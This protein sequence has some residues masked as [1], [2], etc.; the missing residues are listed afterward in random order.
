M[1]ALHFLQKI[2]Q[3]K[4]RMKLSK[5]VNVFVLVKNTHT[6]THKRWVKT[7]FKIALNTHSNKCLKSDE[8]EID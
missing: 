2:E 6:H 4:K 8:N 5:A 1:D 3:K 7:K